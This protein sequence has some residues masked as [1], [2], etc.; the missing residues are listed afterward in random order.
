MVKKNNKRKQMCTE[1]ILLLSYNDD[2]HKI[3]KILKNNVNEINKKFIGFSNE[4]LDHNILEIS[5]NCSF[6]CNQFFVIKI[7]QC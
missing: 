2:Q 1:N 4:Q 5:V 3:V 7:R 6:V